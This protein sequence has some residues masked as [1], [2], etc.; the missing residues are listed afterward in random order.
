MAGKHPGN[1]SKNHRSRL[2]KRYSAGGADSF[3]D[4]LLMELL[5][6][7][8]IPRVDTYPAAHKL[9]DTFGSIEKVFGADKNELVKIEGIGPKTAE[10][11][12]L[13]GDVI[14]RTV[15][16]RLSGVPLLTESSAAPYLLWTFRNLEADTSAL[17]LLDSKGMLM[18]RNVFLPSDS[19]EG[20][21][22]ESAKDILKN[23]RPKYAVL[24]HKHPKKTD[25]PSPEDLSLTKKFEALCKDAGTTALA[26]YIVTDTEVTAVMRHSENKG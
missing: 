18:E 24:A 4:Y 12:E 6:F 8:F 13:F 16:Q 14:E 22:L 23:R 1:E 2:R 7:E 25:E 26:H 10:R 3:D 9:I 20:T 17:L 5:L 19:K 21:L 11:I 15:A